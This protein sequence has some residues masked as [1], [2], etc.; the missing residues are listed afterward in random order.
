[1]T[2]DFSQIPH[3][4]L[5]CLNKE[6]AKSTTCLRQIAVSNIPET[7]SCWRIVSPAYLSVLKG[8]CPYYR[9]LTKARF[10]KG[11]IKALEN[12]P[13]KQMKVVISNLIFTFSQR[14]YYRIRKGDR[15]LSPSEQQIVLD[16]FKDSGV[17]CTPEFDAYEENYDW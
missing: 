13:H 2:I 1:M 3:K 6:C 15:L 7:V 9:S 11:F 17:L 4:Y 16:I 10:A 14:T 8:D 5:M 12:L